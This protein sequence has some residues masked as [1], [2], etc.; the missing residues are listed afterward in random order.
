MGKTIFRD[1]GEAENEDLKVYLSYCDEGINGDYNEDDPEDEPLLRIDVHARNEEGDDWNDEASYSTCTGFCAWTDEENANKIAEMFLANLIK[2]HWQT[3]FKASCYEALTDTEYDYEIYML[4]KEN[5]DDLEKAIE[6]FDNTIDRYTEPDH[7]Q[8]TIYHRLAKLKEEKKGK[9]YMF[10]ENLFKTSMMVMV[11]CMELEK[12]NKEI[13]DWMED[14]CRDV[15]YANLAYMVYSSIGNKEP[16]KEEVFAATDRL[17]GV[18]GELNRYN[19]LSLSDK[20]DSD[21]WLGV[22]CGNYLGLPT[23]ETMDKVKL[24]LDEFMVMPKYGYLGEIIRTVHKD[25]MI[26]E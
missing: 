2:K 7:F 11:R 8:L 18:G 3:S 14:W 22:T 12:E 9:A 1:C 17:L 16:Q 19:S 26:Q 21:S 25:W 5:G 6:F 20:A 24:L 23:R 15:E 13:A 4:L 10:D